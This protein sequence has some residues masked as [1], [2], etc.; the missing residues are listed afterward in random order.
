MAY[1]SYRSESAVART[2]S[3]ALCCIGQARESCSWVAATADE[4]DAF[5]LAGCSAGVRRAKPDWTGVPPQTPHLSLGKGT[6]RKLSRAPHHADSSGLTAEAAFLAGR[7]APC[8]TARIRDDV[9]FSADLV[10]DS[11][12]GEAEGRE[13]RAPGQRSNA[14]RL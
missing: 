10:A 5:Q 2:Y 12:R 11:T 7:G 1:V 13:Q 4:T 14:T 9:S 3:F 6:A 8:G